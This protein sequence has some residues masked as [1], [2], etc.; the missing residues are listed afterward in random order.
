MSNFEKVKD[1]KMRMR[2]EMFEE[3]LEW[4]RNLKSN[5]LQVLLRQLQDCTPFKD[6]DFFY[7]ARYN[8]II[9]EIIQCA[10][11]LKVK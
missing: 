5:N 1:L 6:E 7:T 9:K 10:N 4:K 8:K 2:L 11:K 3:L